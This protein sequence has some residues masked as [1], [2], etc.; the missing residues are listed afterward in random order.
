MKTDNK[1][2]L[3]VQNPAYKYGLNQ[4]VMYVDLSNDDPIVVG[5]ITEIRITSKGVEYSVH[6]TA[7]NGYVYEEV[8]EAELYTD[9]GDIIQVILDA[10]REALIKF[11]E[12]QKITLRNK[13]LS[14]A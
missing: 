12:Q 10:K 13:K 5:M 3:E 2:E 6:S 14:K 7:E 1:T 11:V 4:I 9:M 8:E